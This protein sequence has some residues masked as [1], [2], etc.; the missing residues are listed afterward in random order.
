MLNGVG[1]KELI[2]KC[3]KMVQVSSGRQL[4]ICAPPPASDAGLERQARA[5]TAMTSLF[6][7]YQ[8]PIITPQTLLPTHWPGFKKA[9][10]DKEIKDLK[11]F[12]DDAKR[13]KEN[14]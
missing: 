2:L 14:D 11:I 5:A 13:M 1:L 12:H 10:Q 4:S 6:Q 3:L 9:G 7:S 8:I